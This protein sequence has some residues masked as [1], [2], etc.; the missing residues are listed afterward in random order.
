MPPVAGSHMRQGL[1]VDDAE[2]VWPES[3]R[4]KIVEKNWRSIFQVH[5]DDVEKYGLEYCIYFHTLRVLCGMFFVLALLATPALLFCLQGNSFVHDDLLSHLARLTL[6]NVSPTTMLNAG[7]FNLVLADVADPRAVGFGLLLALQLAIPPLALSILSLWSWPRLASHADLALEPSAADYALRVDGLPSQL[8]LNG[9]T[10]EAELLS[11][12]EAVLRERGADGLCCDVALRR[13]FRGALQAALDMQAWEHKAAATVRQT[14]GSRK[15]RHAL[16]RRE[17]AARRVALHRRDEAERP[18]CSAFVVLGSEEER[19]WLLKRYR[20]AQFSIFRPLQPRNLR[21]QRRWP[22]SLSAAPEPSDIVWTNFSDARILGPAALPWQCVVRVST[23]AFLLVMFGLGSGGCLLI[24]LATLGVPGEAAMQCGIWSL[25]DPSFAAWNSACNCLCACEHVKARLLDTSQCALN[26][27]ESSLAVLA[28]I[29]LVEM[30]QAISCWGLGW[31]MSFWK[32]NCASQLEASKVLL[33]AVAQACV[34][35][36]PACSLFAL[37]WLWQH[38]VLT[39]QISAFAAEAQLQ[40]L[41]LAFYIYAIPIICTWCLLRWL[42]II[43]E[44]FRICRRSHATSFMLWKH[45]ASVVAVVSVTIACQPLAPCLA[46][47]AWVGMLIWYC[48]IKSIIVRGVVTVRY[49]M[50]VRLALRTAQRIA[51]MLWA[52]S[53]IGCCL[54]TWALQQPDTHGVEGLLGPAL[55]SMVLATILLALPCLLWLSR[56]LLWLLCGMGSPPGTWRPLIRNLRN[57]R[58][59]EG[60]AGSWWSWRTQKTPP[61]I[62]FHEA[63]LI[64]RHR[65]ILSTYSLSDHPE[66]QQLLKLLMPERALVQMES[67]KEASLTGYLGRSIDMTCSRA[68]VQESAPRRA[69]L[70]P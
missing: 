56:R 32:F 48:A 55:P 31:L 42:V 69:P 6:G 43:P 60:S 49:G 46:C 52:A 59:N 50:P 63:W 65:A 29:V 27:V 4:E 2:V 38:Q 16:S 62:N 45:Y 51:A 68:V 1:D 10:L 57:P 9:R 53:F 64:M 41:D 61:R 26:D 58:P 19:D 70:P 15:A 47:I 3:A 7:P 13:N 20:F 33:T 54:A 17:A 28:C 24:F 23:V 35:L 8:E 12:F 67:P 11:H 39:T 25:Q 18:V 40:Q 37:K 34:P 14:P 21:L 22:L 44:A 30:L 66:Y 36:S 5:L